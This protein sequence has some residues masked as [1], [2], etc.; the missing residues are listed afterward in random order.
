MALGIQTPGNQPTSDQSTRRTLSVGA[1]KPVKSSETRFVEATSEKKDRL[2]VAIAGPE[3]YGKNHLAFTAEGPIYCQ[4]IDPGAED[5]KQKYIEGGPFWDGER[6]IYVSTYGIEISQE[7]ATDEDKMAAAA[8]PVWNQWTADYIYALDHARTIVW[9]TESDAW[10]LLRLARF[11]VLNPK[12]GR[13]RGN[14]WGPVNAE[15]RR[16]L[17]LAYDKD[18]NF[19]LIQKVKDE[20]VNDKKS[21]RKERKGFADVGYIVQVVATAQ[22]DGANFTLMITDCRQDPTLNGQVIPSNDFSMLKGIVLP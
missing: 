22:R 19:I 7:D 1:R 4:S 8:D 2:V 14:A 20:Y 16:L 11:G 17:R 5:M 21:G 9:D 6:K 15:Y 10:E 13:D 18:V 12:T 3:K